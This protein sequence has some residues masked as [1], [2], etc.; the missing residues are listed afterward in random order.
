MKRQATSQQLVHDAINENIDIVTDKQAKMK[1]LWRLDEH[2]PELCMALFF[3]VYLS[4]CIYTDPCTRYRF[5]E[6]VVLLSVVGVGNDGLN[7]LSRLLGDAGHLFNN[8]RAC[9][10]LGSIGG[11]LGNNRFGFWHTLNANQF[12]FED[13]R[14]EMDC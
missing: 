3:F 7:N 11:R 8:L 10:G 9:R 2:G 14:D 5:L 6:L 1:Q 12:R 4:V 13:C